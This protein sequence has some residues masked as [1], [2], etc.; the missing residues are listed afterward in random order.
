[1]VLLAWGLLFTPQLVFPGKVMFYSILLLCSLVSITWKL[2]LLFGNGNIFFFFLGPHLQ[3]TEAPRL[4]VK[5]ELQLPAYAEA[6]ATPDLSCVCDL[7]RNMSRARDQ[8][9]ILMDISRVPYPWATTGTPAIVSFP[10]EVG[11]TSSLWLRLF[12]ATEMFIQTKN[13]VFQWHSAVCL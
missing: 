7:H 2:P 6:T 12:S 3:H 1:M 13:Q 5:S 9:H 10:S 8:T 4:G 11:S